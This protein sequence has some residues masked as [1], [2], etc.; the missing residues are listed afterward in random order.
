MHA[1]KNDRQPQAAVLPPSV[2]YFINNGEGGI[3]TRGTQKGTPV[4][5]TGSFSHSDTSPSP[6][7]KQIQSSY[8]LLY[9]PNPYIARRLKANSEMIY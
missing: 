4:F 9:T 7:K 6:N 2:I 3:R 5:E 8:C 1:L